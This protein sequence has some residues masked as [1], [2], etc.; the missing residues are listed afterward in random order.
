[1][2]L[3]NK[4]LYDSNVMSL[5][6]KRKG[7]WLE[8]FVGEG[9]WCQPGVEARPFPVVVFVGVGEKEGIYLSVASFVRFVWR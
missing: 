7:C 3:G 8:G 6:E 1:M 4:Q 9:W 2:E 5:C